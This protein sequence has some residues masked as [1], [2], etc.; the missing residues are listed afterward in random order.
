MANMRVTL[1]TDGACRG[2]PGRGGYGVLLIYYAPSGKEYRHEMSAG[3]EL[4]TNNRMELLAVIKGL[5]AL[6]R[7][8]DVRVYSDSSY[9]CDGFN[10][11]WIN[12][13]RRKGWRTSSGRTVKNRDLWERLW[14]AAQGH[15][16]EFHWL[17]GHAFSDGNNRC[18]ELATSAADAPGRLHDTVFEGLPAIDR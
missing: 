17:K 8:C 10:K 11:G 3:Y 16:V 14:D 7:P 13:W 12:G 5:E 18:D 1:Y 6:R 15:N 9:V 2:N 4:T